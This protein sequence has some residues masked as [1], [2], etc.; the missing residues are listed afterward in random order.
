MSDF[1]SLGILILCAII[2]ASLQLVPGV[3]L[4]ASHFLAGRFSRKKASDLAIFFILGAETS[5]AIVF[6]SVYFILCALSSVINVFHETIFSWIISGVFVVLSILSACLYFRKGLGTKLFISHTIAED[7]QIKAHTIKSRSDAFI[8]GLISIIPELPF[9]LPIYLVATSE[10]IRL[11]SGS[12]SRSA[13][14]IAFIL[15]SI[16]PLLIIHALYN[17]LNLADFIRLRFNNKNYHR[18]ILFTS[19]LLIATLIVLRNLL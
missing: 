12:I 7:Y 2:M 11:G 15:I 6:I 4:L 10:I 16:L 1:T 18:A 5:F 3:F 19:Y 13:L 8:L 14:A 9:T 17:Y